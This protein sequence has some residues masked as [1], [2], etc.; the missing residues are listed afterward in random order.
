[1]SNIQL[2]QVGENEI[3]VS[4]AAET[5]ID[6]VHQ[7][8][9]SLTIRGFVENLNKSTLAIRYFHRPTDKVNDLADTLIKSL[10]K[11]APSLVQNVSSSRTNVPGMRGWSM[12]S[13]TGSFHHSTHGVVSPRKNKAGGF[14]LI[15][16]GKTVGN[17]N[18]MN[19]LAGKFREYAGSL[20]P[21]ET[22]HIDPEMMKSGVAKPFGV[23]MYDSKANIKRKAK[24][25]GESVENIGPNKNVK[26]YSGKP[27]KLSNKQ[28]NNLQFK[29]DAKKYTKTI[30]HTPEEKAKIMAEYQARELN[31]RLK[32]GKEDQT[33]R[34][35]DIMAN[36]LKDM[37][38][39]KSILG[40][41]PPPQPSDQEMFGHLA[42][43]EE[44][45]Q[46]AEQQWNGTI[47][48]WLAE[49]MKPLSSRFS[50]EE[51]ELAYWD[52]IKVNGSSGGEGQD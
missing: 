47:N 45:A 51:E 2:K 27:G 31:N 43:S 23:N 35:E 39:N 52:S 38:L 13:S 42:V 48:N 7:L 37:M 11:A 12:D 21:Q 26:P 10:S 24:N 9:K 5:P 4:L 3:E 17:A 14:D 40:A 15:H 29:R 25:V 46:V 20:Q 44:Q 8:I 30:E 32:K 36:Q 6:E 34:G 18:D 28:Q 41:T 22:G 16:A 33:K 19:S 50:S 49:A 1:M